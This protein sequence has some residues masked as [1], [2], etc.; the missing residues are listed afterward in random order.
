LLAEATPR[1]RAFPR[2]VH[3]EPSTQPSKIDPALRFEDW[4]VLSQL[5]GDDTEG[6]SA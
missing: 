6:G 5:V 2:D 4:V 1:R 3:R